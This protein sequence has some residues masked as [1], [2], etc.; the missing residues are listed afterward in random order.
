MATAVFP[1]SEP[2]QSDASHLDASG[3]I[4]TRVDDRHGWGFALLLATTATLF[5]RPAD[6]I[7][8]LDQWPIYQALI[9]ACLV[10][11]A[12]ALMRQFGTV[13]LV[14]RPV[15][16]CMLM[17]LFAIGASH[18]SHGFVWG[19]RSSM[20]EFA[21][22]LTLYGLVVGLVN[23]PRRLSLFIKWLTLAITLTAALAVLDHFQYVAIAALESVQDRGVEENGVVEKVERIRGTGIFQDPNDFGLILATGCI[24]CG[25]YL[26]RPDAGILRYTWL[27]PAMMLLV[28]M[29]LTQSRGALLA[30]LSAVPAI[31]MFFRCSRYLVI[32]LLGLPIL[33][34]MFSSRMTDISSISQGTGQSRLQ[35]WS[36]TLQ[37]FQQYPIFG[38]GE[39]LLSDELGVVAHNSFLHCYA[40]LGLLGGT[41]FLS[42]FFAAGWSLWTL[43]KSV[44]NPVHRSVSMMPANVPMDG[45]FHPHLGTSEQQVA[46]SKS[47]IGFQPVIGDSQAGSLCHL[48]FRGSLVCNE[49]TDGEILTPKASDANAFCLKT[50]SVLSHQCAFLFA[51]LVACAVSMLTLSRQFVAPTYLILGLASA[52][53][54]LA[55]ERLPMP[56]CAGPRIGN[57]FLLIAGSA[58]ALFLMATYLI[59]RL[60]VRW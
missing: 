23:T 46:G 56:E 32:P 26:F 43:R 13:K 16:I 44:K 60:F 53:Y 51:A 22:L 35:I 3:T 18:L 52:G 47:G 28:A 50:W 57:R 21:K 5:L 1:Q 17:L 37:V 45:Q 59:I 42:C 11:S 40:E 24:F 30:L 10:V 55:I 25:S 6:L 34:S 58:N 39:G 31:F 14:H 19:A 12:P 48:L 36:E 38:L 8:S 20:F 9:L 54:S 2:S 15:T 41:A 4:D 29:S 33:I 7:P 27:V 49:T